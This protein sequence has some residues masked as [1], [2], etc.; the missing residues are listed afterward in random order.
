MRTVTYKSLLEGFLR[1]RSL[2]PSLALTVEKL[3]AGEFLA[4]ALADAHEFWRWPELMA[5]QGRRFR[6]TWTATTYAEDD[7]VWHTATEAYYRANASA[8]GSEVPGT[9]TLWDE[10]TEFRRYVEYAQTGA[11]VIEAVIEA[12][13]A[14]PRASAS[15]RKVPFRL[16]TDGVRFAPD[17]PD[18][19]WLEFRTPA[20]DFGWSAL[21][22]ATSF[23]ADAVVYH[24][25]TGEVYQASSAA[26]S[27]DVPG[28]AAKWV[29]QP[30]PYIFRHAAKLKAYAT[31]SQSKGASD[32]ALTFDN[33]DPAKPGKF[34]TALEEQVWQY[35]KLQG[36]T[37]R[38]QHG[39]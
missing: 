38:A 7:E 28:T 23:A 21:W 15:A 39:R 14:D 16:D 29:L 13:D 10:I 12:W 4:Q 11:T 1:M 37:G 34:Q 22:A 18:I 27:G 17:G 33:N 31:W 32:V 3:E 9:S 36:Q 8:A 6:P 25:S 24:E 2:D 19:A 26:A 5:T 35:T 30:V 20:P